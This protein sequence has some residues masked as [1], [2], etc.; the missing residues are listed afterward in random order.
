MVTGM[1]CPH[2]RQHLP[3]LLVCTVLTYNTYHGYWYAL[4]SHRTMLT[5]VTG[6]HCP[7]IGQ[8]LPWLLV[9]TVRT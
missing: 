4:S 1:H 6:I 2:I 7:H 9:C 3:W 5:M 8:H